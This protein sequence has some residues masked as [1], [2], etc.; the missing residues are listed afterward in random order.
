MHRHA[1]KVLPL[2]VATMATIAGCT[3]EA[4]P[5]ATATSRH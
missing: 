3:R 1:S 2:A 4:K 5:D